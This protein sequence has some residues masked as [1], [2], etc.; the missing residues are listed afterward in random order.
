MEN[1]LD[2]N[3]LF[4]RSIGQT[5]GLSSPRPSDLHQNRKLDVVFFTFKYNVI[6]I[7]TNERP[8]L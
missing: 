5:K 7:V 1:I 4:A 6:N 3:D 2:V 8:K